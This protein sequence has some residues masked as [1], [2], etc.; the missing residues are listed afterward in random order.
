MRKTVDEFNKMRK[1]V[2]KAN[3]MKI[4]VAETN[5]MRKDGLRPFGLGKEK[6][7]LTV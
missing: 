7:R 6:V 5:E 2:D 4:I 1:R 3:R